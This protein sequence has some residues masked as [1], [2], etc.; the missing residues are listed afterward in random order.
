MMTMMKA[1]ALSGRVSNDGFT[2]EKAKRLS[3][4]GH[5]HQPNVKKLLLIFMPVFFLV[6]LVWFDTPHLAQ[7]L[8]EQFAS[9]HL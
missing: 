2:R 4:M 9:T 8:S 7:E 3:P 5:S 6:A 1:L